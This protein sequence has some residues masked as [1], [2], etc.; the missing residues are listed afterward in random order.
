MT[1]IDI[2]AQLRAELLTE[3][4]DSCRAEAARPARTPEGRDLAAAYADV[5]AILESLTTTLAGGIRCPRTW[6]G[7]HREEE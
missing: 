4:A 6:P 5:A 7:S 3:L 1:T 2:P